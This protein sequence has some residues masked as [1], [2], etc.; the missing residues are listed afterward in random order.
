[1]T[2]RGDGYQIGYT[3]KRKRPMSRAE[4]RR[5]ALDR[6]MT[7]PQGQR[8]P[9]SEHANAVRIMEIATGLAEEEYAP[10][11][12]PPEKKPKVRIL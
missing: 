8:R 11:H 7:G 9:M 2:T 4:R 5:A 12:F 6:K 1:M 10:G 3:P